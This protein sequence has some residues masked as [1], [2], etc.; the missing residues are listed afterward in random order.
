VTGRGGIFIL[1][2]AL[3]LLQCASPSEE[4]VPE[5]VVVEAMVQTSAET[6][7]IKSAVD[8]ESPQVILGALLRAYP[9]KLG[10]LEFRGGDWSFLV[11]G[12]P[13]FWAGGRL[14]PEGQL[15]NAESFVP[16]QFHPYPE[17]LPPL[18]ELSSE[19]LEQLQAMLVQRESRNDI[20]SSD[21][22]T[23]LWGMDDFLTAENT[24]IGFDFLSFHIRIHPGIKDALKQVEEEILTAAVSDEPTARWLGTLNTAGAYVWRDIAGSGNR[25]LHSYGIAIDLIPRD[26][27]GKQ[28]YWRWAA[29]YND[30]WWSIPYADRFQVPDAVIKAFEANGFIWGGKWRLFDQ[31]HFEYRPE[32]M[33]LGEISGL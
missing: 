6:V 19:E 14:L 33:I 18:H 8:V 32:L 17:T 5:R 11:D 16:Y 31:I 12:V 13:Y 3:F 25:S 29:D 20:R 2:A 21:F 9:E 28:A 23:A 30:E 24:V 15:G 1:P 27:R 10:S 22:M 4:P 7:P 26:Y